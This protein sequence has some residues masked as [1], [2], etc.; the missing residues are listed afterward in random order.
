MENIDHIKPGRSEEDILHEVLLKLGLD[1]FAPV[2]TRKI[3]D[4]SVRSIGAGTL[5]T[6]LDERIVPKEAGSLAHGIAEWP[7]ELAPA[8]DSTVVFRDSAFADDVAKTNVAAILEQR[9]LE[10]VRSL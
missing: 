7:D 5:I 8:G 10:N 2:D 9:R 3:V 4:K 6:C 1:L